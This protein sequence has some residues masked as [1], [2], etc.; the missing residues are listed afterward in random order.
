MM[1]E[2]IILSG[3]GNGGICLMLRLTETR[4]GAGECGSGEVHPPVPGRA[5]QRNN[6]RQNGIFVP[7]GGN[8][9]KHCV[10]EKQREIGG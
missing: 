6:C 8:T 7:A 4:H 5:T 1:R 10:T 2:S 9:A 3:T